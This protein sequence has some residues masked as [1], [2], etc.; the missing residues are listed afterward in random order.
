MRSVPTAVYRHDKSPARWLMLQLIKVTFPF[1]DTIV[2]NSQAVKKD[3]SESLRLRNRK[4]SVIYNPLDVEHFDRLSRA[5]I[6][7]PWTG[8]DAPTV[9]LAV[10]SLAILK[11]F[12]TLIRA[13]SIVRK[14]RDCRLAILG[15][16]PD[17]DKLEALIG[18]LGVQ[19]DVLLP[20]FVNNPFPWFRRAALFVS[21]SLTEGCP[22]AL[23][24][25]LACNTPIVSTDCI[26]GSAEIL[27]DGKWGR[28]VATRDAEAMAEAILQTL[29]S[30]QDI[31]L[32]QRANDFA[33]DKVVNKYLH[34]LVPD[35]SSHA[36]DEQR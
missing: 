35:D 15:E 36:T 9:V 34:V 16:G 21:S 18:E 1:A 20:G 26:G 7:H 30:E 13:F 2:A 32:V 14:T 5:N 6:D 22:N 4:F 24:Q 8:P 19:H 17:R 10:G 3:L 11:D 12:P 31:E 29:D 23:M 27:Q 25:A 28:L 33:L